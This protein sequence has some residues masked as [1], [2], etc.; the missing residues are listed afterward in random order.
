MTRKHCKRKVWST[1]INP[2]QHAIEGAAITSEALL[3]QLRARELAAVEAF[4]TGSATLQEWADIAGMLNICETMARGGIGPEA[5]EACERAE[6]EL[7]AAGLRFEA[8]R[9]MGYQRAWPAGVPR[10][11]PVPRLAA[12]EHQPVRIRPVDQKGKPASEVQGA[13][14]PRH[15]RGGEVSP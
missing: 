4:R 8:T 2:I 7:I 1:S 10:P 3:N 11:V 14:S 6:R 15:G 12:P 5:L 9:R 13:R